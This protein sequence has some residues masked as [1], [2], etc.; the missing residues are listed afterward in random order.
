MKI[1][2]SL[3]IVVKSLINSNNG[4][5]ILLLKSKWGYWDLP[6][7]HIKFEE[8]PEECLEREVKEEIGVEVS[9]VNLSSIQTVIL[10][11]SYQKEKPEIIHYSVLIFNCRID[12]NG[13]HFVFNDKEVVNC[14]W[15]NKKRVINDL[16][17]I[18]LPF[19]RDLINEL[20][21]TKKIRTK[22]KY[23]IKEGEFKTYKEIFID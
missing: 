1:Q 19:S 7:G 23:Y 16:N 6:G 9:V 8:T 5:K 18:L 4:Q 10:D 22:K 15:L 11:K 14:A 2:R 13:A 20:R 12:K 3:S 21:D 17:I